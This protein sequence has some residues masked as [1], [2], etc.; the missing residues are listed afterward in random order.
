ML[1]PLEGIAAQAGQRIMAVY[2]DPETLAVT[3]KN[4]R[5]PLTAADLA[6]NEVI[7]AGLAGL[8]PEIPVLSEESADVDYRERKQWTRYWL[9]DPLDGTKE[10]IKHNGEFTVNIALVEN[11]E[12]VL[13]VVYAPAKQLMYSA[14]SG[15]GAKRRYDGAQ[16]QPIV[17]GGGSGDTIRVVGSRSHAGDSLAGFLQRIGNHQLLSIGSSLKLCLVA[18]GSADVYPRLGPTSEWD[19][20]AAQCIVEQAG[21]QVLTLAGKRLDYNCKES[22]LNPQFIVFGHQSR[23]WLADLGT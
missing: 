8:T 22:L 19:T 23:D 14:V 2:E 21:G 10:F 20:A 7:A 6:A 4:D 9:V 12:P 5:S 17:T 3:L 13:G 11:H 1:E 18:E 16:A 15:E